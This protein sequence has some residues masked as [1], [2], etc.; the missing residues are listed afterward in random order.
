[1][2][3]YKEPDR[4]IDAILADLAMYDNPQYLKPEYQK[5]L[6]ESIQAQKKPLIKK[7]FSTLSNLR[8]A[9]QKVLRYEVYFSEFYTNSKQIPPHEALNHHVHSYLQDM[10]TLKNKIQVCLGEVKNDCKKEF[11]NKS[12][13]EEF[14]NEAIKKTEI[15]F[16]QI[17]Q[18]RDPHHHKGPRFLDADIFKAETAHFINTA[19][20]DSKFPLP[21]NEALKPELLEKLEKNKSEAFE[22]AKLRWISTAKSNAIEITG[23]IDML[24][25][26]VKPNF[27]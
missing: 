22:V 24:L 12:D 26:L 2:Q 14:F 3:D 27:Y 7:Y 16:E 18:L 20:S 5:I 11:I 1:M 6:L 9:W 8:A 10:T 25:A 19:I 17:S 13:I 15:V 23:Y 21:I 4:V